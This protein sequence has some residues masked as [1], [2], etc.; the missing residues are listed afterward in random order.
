ML[1]RTDWVATGL[2][3]V[4]TFLIAQVFP[5]LNGPWAILVFLL[6]AGLFGALLRRREA[7]AASP[8]DTK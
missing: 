5:S 8:L 2:A 3:V 6:L 4:A 1:S 7:A